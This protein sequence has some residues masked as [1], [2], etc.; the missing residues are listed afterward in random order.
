[1]VVVRD[2]IRVYHR[3]AEEVIALR[4]MDFEVKHNEFLS[5]VGPSGSGK[6]T[7]IR[8]IG[9]LD[10]PTAGKVYVDKKD[11]TRMND[12]Q[13]IGYRRKV[14]GFVWQFGNLIDSLTALKNVLL[15][16]QAVGVVTEKKKKWAIELLSRLGLEKRMNHKPPELSGGEAQRVAIAVALANKPKLLLG[17]EITGELD[18][19]TAGVV[20]DYLKEIKETYGLTV[21]MVTHNMEVA[22]VG[23]R[24]L[25]IKD[26]LIESYKHAKLG[27][28]TEIDTKGRLVIPEQI[29][30]LLKLGRVV[31]LYVDD[32][33]IVI[34]PVKE[35]Q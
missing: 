20:L 10:K 8:I 1:M 6:T 23:D 9:A 17:D 30:L 27:E 26:G 7:L 4:G 15:P 22:K 25:R 29:R 16:M 11:V 19:E 31:R 3:G 12:L 35:T 21:I 18:S 2:L 24:I 34:E 5:I 14:V 33:K 13:A 28:I 32:G